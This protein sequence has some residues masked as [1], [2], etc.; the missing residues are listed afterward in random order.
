MLDIWIIIKIKTI[1]LR[2][3]VIKIKKMYLCRTELK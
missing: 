1:I 2:K 3:S